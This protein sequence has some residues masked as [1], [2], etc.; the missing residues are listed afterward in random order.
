[1]GLSNYTALRSKWTEGGPEGHALN[2]KFNRLKP[3]ACG[4][5]RI[6]QTRAPEIL[7]KKENFIRAPLPGLSYVQKN[8]ST[9]RENTGILP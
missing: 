3:V 7:K 6:Y 1:M 5:L 8:L 2:E 9:R 4:S